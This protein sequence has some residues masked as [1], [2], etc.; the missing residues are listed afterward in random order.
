M[1]TKKPNFTQQLLNSDAFSNVL[2]MLPKESRLVMRHM[3]PKIS[4]NVLSDFFR[5]PSQG[6]L[7]FDLDEKNEVLLDALSLLKHV[8]T[9]A[10][11][12]MDATNA[13]WSQVEKIAEMVGSSVRDLTLSFDGK[14]NYTL[15]FI[16]AREVLKRFDKITSLTLNVYTGSNL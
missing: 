13:Q 9:V 11:E 14:S 5:E 1:V 4:Q 2:E 12:C 16:S 6:S 15:E 7:T 8:H 10:F 3:G